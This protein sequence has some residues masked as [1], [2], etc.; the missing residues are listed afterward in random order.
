MSHQSPFYHFEGWKTRLS[1][2]TITFDLGFNVWAWPRIHCLGTQGRGI[3]CTMT[4]WWE[5]VFLTKKYAL[6]IRFFSIVIFDEKRPCH[7]HTRDKHEDKRSPHLHLNKCMIWHIAWNGCCAYEKSCLSHALT[8]GLQM[9]SLLFNSG[10]NFCIHCFRA[11]CALRGRETWKEL[12]HLGWNKTLIFVQKLY[13][14][15][16]WK[17]ICTF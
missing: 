5:E 9:R 12:W 4:L 6:K 14:P 3:Q 1:K 8:Y 13:N 15:W 2:D 16:K 11:M 10:L 17:R 7:E